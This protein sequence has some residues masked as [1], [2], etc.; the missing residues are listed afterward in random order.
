MAAPLLS[1]GGLPNKRSTYTHES[2]TQARSRSKE[3]STTADAWKNWH[4]GAQSVRTTPFAVF[5]DGDRSE[6][7][8]KI[9]NAVELRIDLEVKFSILTMLLEKVI[10][11]MMMTTCSLLAKEVG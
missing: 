2:F 9:T 10:G 3:G 1:Q 7:E 11:T 5:E 8:R 6:L 4:T